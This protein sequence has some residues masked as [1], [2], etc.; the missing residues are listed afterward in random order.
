MSLLHPNFLYLSHPASP[1][2]KLIPPGALGWLIM[3]RDGF[4]DEFLPD[5]S[6]I[7]L[8]RCLIHKASEGKVFKFKLQILIPLIYFIASLMLSFSAKLPRFSWNFIFWANFA[9]KS[10]SFFLKGFIGFIHHINWIIN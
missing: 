4:W 8:W 3:S 10:I 9:E 1:D 6:F 7:S 5:F 2:W